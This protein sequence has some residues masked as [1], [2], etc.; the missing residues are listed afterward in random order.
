MHATTLTTDVLIIGGGFAGLWASRQAATRSS[1]SMSP[2]SLPKDRASTIPLAFRMDTAPRAKD[3]AEAAAHT[4]GS[5]KIRSAPP[6]RAILARVHLSVTAGRPCWTQ[7]PLITATT[8][9]SG[10]S[11]AFRADI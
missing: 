2:L 4:V 3:S 1:C 9:V 6:F 11:C 5:S 7:L 8:E 10:P